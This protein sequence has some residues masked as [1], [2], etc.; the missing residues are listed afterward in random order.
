MKVGMTVPFALMLCMAPLIS[1]GQTCCSGGV[2][3]SSNLGM[4][5]N[6]QGIWQFSISYDHL[7]LSTLKEGSMLID[8]Q[9]R[10]RKTQSILTEIGYGIT[11]RIAVD[12]FIPY[13]YQQRR[14][15]QFG[16]TD[17]VTTNGIGDV[18]LLLKYKLTDPLDTRQN[19][20]I[21][22]G[23][24]MPTGKTD[25]T[26]TDGIL[27]NADLQ[28]G[29]GAW[30]GLIYAFYNRSFSFRPSMGFSLS[31]VISIKGVNQD[32]LNG[33][34]YQFGNELVSQ[35]SFSDKINLGKALFDLSLSLRFRKQLSDSFND[36]F[37]PNTGGHF[38]FFTPGIAYFLSSSTSIIVSGDVPI[39]TYVDGTQL[40]PSYRLNIGLFVTLRKKKNLDTKTIKL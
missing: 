7:V 25:F 9:S 32:Y 27:L 39:Y 28:P 16:K 12:V 34:S 40:A 35:L 33:Q 8:D 2:P 36:T 6:D 14:I 22:I 23:P 37:L 24:K 21:G 17:F 18:A 4:P 29:S 31:T 20:L 1:Y 11:K 13:V 19:L 30:D 38:L 5:P 26:R 3:L 15:E 10:I